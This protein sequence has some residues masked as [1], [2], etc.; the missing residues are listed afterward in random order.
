MA[1][2]VALWRLGFF[3]E[4]RLVEAEDALDIG[5]DEGVDDSKAGAEFTAGNEF[6]DKGA[7][8]GAG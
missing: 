7:T 6:D 4:F 8:G 2:G 3:V 5:V 1:E